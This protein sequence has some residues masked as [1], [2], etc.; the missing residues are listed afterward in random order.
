MNSLSFEVVFESDETL[1]AG[2]GV[3]NLFRFSDYELGT[4]YTFLCKIQAAVLVSSS[5]LKVH[6]I[7]LPSNVEAFGFR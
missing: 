7:D 5:M 6:S 4:L 3:K 2:L 1:L